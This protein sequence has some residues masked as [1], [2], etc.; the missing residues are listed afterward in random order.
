MGVLQAELFV[1]QSMLTPRVDL[2]DVLQ[3]EVD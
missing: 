2:M 1:A 3:M